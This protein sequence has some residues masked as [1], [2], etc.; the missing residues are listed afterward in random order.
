MRPLANSSSL[1]IGHWQTIKKFTIKNVSHKVCFKK[2]L[3]D[4]KERP[5]TQIV[6]LLEEHE[7]IEY[8]GDLEETHSKRNIEFCDIQK[9]RAVHQHPLKSA[10]LKSAEDAT[11]LNA[12]TLHNAYNVG[13]AFLSE[14]QRKV[15]MKESC[16]DMNFLHFSCLHFWFHHPLSP[17]ITEHL[18]LS[19][20]ETPE[21]VS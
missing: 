21:Q 14:L 5:H 13:F 4:L 12:D 8:E 3:A 19:I 17:S 15:H 10:I 18:C 20:G 6:D 1:S 7:R 11:A 9:E 16:L 2:D